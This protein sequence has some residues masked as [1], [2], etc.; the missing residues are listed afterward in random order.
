[1]EEKR[2]RYARHE[3][4]WKQDLLQ[5]W[6]KYEAYRKSTLWAPIQIT[7]KTKAKESRAP[8]FTTS[9]DANSWRTGHQAILHLNP[10]MTSNEYDSTLIVIPPLRGKIENLVHAL[11]SIPAQVKTINGKP[12]ILID[13][14][15]IVVFSYPYYTE[16][17][18]DIERGT[19]HTATNVLFLSVFLDLF[20]ANKKQVAVLVK[21]EANAFGVGLALEA[22]RSGSTRNAP[23]VNF[24]EPAYA[25]YTIPS[26]GDPSEIKAVC[27]TSAG[28][29]TE[30]SIPYVY[31]E[32]APLASIPRL[33]RADSTAEAASV[34]KGVLVVR[35]S[36]IGKKMPTGLRQRQHH[37]K[38]TALESSGEAKDVYAFIKDT[39]DPYLNLSLTITPTEAGVDKADLFW[40]AFRFRYEQPARPLCK[41]D[42]RQEGESVLVTD[43]FMLSPEAVTTN[44]SLFPIL[45]AGATEGDPPRTYQIRIPTDENR[46]TQDWLSQ[47]FTED[48]ALYLNS[49]GFSPEILEQAFVNRRDDVSW[50]YLLAEF[51]TD[52][53]STNCFLD[54]QMI[55][56]SRCERVREFMEAIHTYFIEAN[57]TKTDVETKQNEAVRDELERLQ[58]YERRKREATQASVQNQPT[59][60]DGAYLEPD[61]F[62]TGKL[63]WGTLYV[64][65][66]LGEKVQMKAAN[67]L[68]IQKDTGQHF[69]YSVRVPADQYKKDPNLLY[70]KVE[71]L[72]SRH[73][74]YFFIY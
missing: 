33:I 67:V 2:L 43:R 31:A 59:L 4:A 32:T 7:T 52:L 50:Q 10:A 56:D 39:P 15:V 16:F 57:L 62:R 54:T 42:V 49:L 34:S 24:L 21:H 55:T 71:G 23:L 9:T 58:N 73:P 41:E 63:A 8:L 60:E 48:E 51:L 35:G 18:L 70:K 28:L 64:Y 36:T 74:G 53:L 12:Q 5:K 29:D 13:P 66:I 11:E 6:D 27:V 22:Y 17:P 1:M 44:V 20:L 14:G 3:R 46:V 40:L 68:I 30:K 38:C 72:R 65:D 69:Y 25:L 47:K 19:D 45:G 37:D 26:D 61:Q